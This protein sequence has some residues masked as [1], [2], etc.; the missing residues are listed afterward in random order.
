MTDALNAV[1]ADSRVAAARRA[2]HAADDRTLA[3]QAELSAIPSPT[4]AERPRAE[5]VAEL[6]R[7][8]GLADVA[9]DELANVTGRLGPA[10]GPAVLVAAHCDTVF[11]AGTDVT[12]R[13]RGGRLEGPGISDNARGLAALVTVA[14]ALVA[15]GVVPGR[16]VRFAAT[17]GEEGAGDLRGVRHLLL[18]ER[19]A[20][21]VAV[22]GAGVERVVHRG[23][24]SHRYRAVFRGPGG[25]SWS[26][27]G[28]ANAAS[29]AGRAAAGVAE[30]RFP[31]SP[32]TTCSVVGLAGGVG[33][34]MIPP[35]ASLELDLRSES[36][37]ALAAADAALRGTLEA[38]R[39]AENA[40]RVAGTPPLALALE[41]LGVRPCGVTP[42]SHPLV[43]AAVAASAAL[44]LPHELAASSTDANAA[45]AAGVP[46]IAIG[47]G[48][49]AGDTHRLTEWYDNAQGPLGVERALLVI[50]LAARD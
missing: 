11:P 33:L 13:R 35:E 43:R 17:A 12:V 22:D 41:P 1:L 49:R 19:P 18:R 48:G 32:R 37:D 4:G 36:A 40:R 9:L 20:A 16:A 6:F 23:I 44:G 31:A 26:A 34:N 21:F 15:A 27:H 3:L 30:L 28:V 38:A 42:A 10:D 45:M 25:H 14:E 46:A 2:V 5:R 8:A 50:L 7:A 24:G 47:A 39:D 29:A